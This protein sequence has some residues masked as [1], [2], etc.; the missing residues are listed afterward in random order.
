MLSM[1]S[2]SSRLARIGAVGVASFFVASIIT[3]ALNP[4]YSHAREAVSALAATDARFAWIMITGFMISAVGMSSTG[5]ALW[6]RFAGNRAARAA[7]GIMMLAGPL[8]VVAGLA[9]QDCSERL[10][11][12]VDFGEGTGASSHFWVHQYVSLL[13]FVLMTVALFLLAR[14][15]RR[16]D[17]MSGFAVPTRVAGLFCLLVIVVMIVDEMKSIDSYAGLA[18]R[19]FVLVLFGW[20][21]VVAAARCRPELRGSDRL[22]SRRRQQVGA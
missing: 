12:C 19:A 16:D 2:E 3:A 6:R 15:L 14:G 5:I 13:L 18:Q 11:T 17:G 10:P 9:R 20:P 4:G 7:A 22:E 21:V 8:M 1:F